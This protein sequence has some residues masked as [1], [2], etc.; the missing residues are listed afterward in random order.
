MI[1]KK[2]LYFSLSFLIVIILTLVII[3]FFL[4][5]ISIIYRN[6]PMSKDKIYVY[7]IGESSSVGEPY[8]PKISYYKILN[9]MIGGK[10]DNKD[11]EFIEIAQSGNNINEQYW[12]YL[13]YRYLHPF[14]KGLVFV[15]A[16]KNNWD[17]GENKNYLKIPKIKTFRFIKDYFFELFDFQYNYEELVLTLKDFGETVFVATIEGNYAG[18]MPHLYS[19][20]LLYREEFDRIDDEIIINKNYDKAKMLLKELEDKEDSDKSWIYYRYGKI[21][22]FTGKIK[23]ANDFFIKGIGLYHNL[24]PSKYQIDCIRELAKKYNLELVDIF[25]EVYNSGEIIGFNFYKDNQHPDIKLYI[26]I[27]KLFVEALKNKYNNTI[28]VVNNEV[29]EQD[30]YNIFD[31]DNKDIYNVY[32]HSLDVTLVHSKEK[33]KENKNVNVNRYVFKQVDEYLNKV[34]EL[35]PYEGEQRQAIISFY[36]MMVEALKGNKDKMVEIYNKNKDIIQR[37]KYKIYARSCDWKEY[38]KWVSYYLGIEE[39]FDLK[40]EAGF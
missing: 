18:F 3:E 14:K 2:T 24:I 7:I 10:I 40:S 9:Y 20:N 30:L 15:Y 8:N 26:R 4:Q 21:N 29:T 35:N 39:F 16:G 5:S 17:K 13:K 25:N 1:I 12:K 28:N 34:I 31:F 6:I 33:E 37:N 22:E 27:A 19:E 23:D 38:N 32:R 36:S 11:I